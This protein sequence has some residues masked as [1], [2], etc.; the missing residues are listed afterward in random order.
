MSRF[1]RSRRARAGSLSNSSEN[2]HID[3]EDRREPPDPIL[4]LNPNIRSR[5]VRSSIY[6]LLHG[7]TLISQNR[8]LE[9]STNNYLGMATA[10]VVNGAIAIIA[11]TYLCVFCLGPYIRVALGIKR[12]GEMDAIKEA[13]RSGNVV[14]LNRAIFVANF[15]RNMRIR[16]ER[17]RMRRL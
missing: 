12:P 5:S 7:N 10:V 1:R 15:M 8:L 2:S 6:A 11:S 3:E 17:N 4:N 14:V 13:I 16:A 9:D